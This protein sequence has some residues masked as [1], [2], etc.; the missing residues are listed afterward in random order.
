MHLK[1]FYEKSVHANAAHYYGLAKASREKAAGLEKA[2]A[3]TKKELEKAEKERQGGKKSRVKRDRE[4]YEQFH[5]SFTSG[6]KLMLGGRS[7]KQNA[8]MEALQ[9]A[10]STR[11]LPLWSCRPSS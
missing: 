7:A 9:S 10:I 5:F 6:G 2:I 3:E 1:L 8:F 4:W 11:E